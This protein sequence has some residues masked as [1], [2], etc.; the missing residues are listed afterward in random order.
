VICAEGS[1]FFPSHPEVPR[2]PAGQRAIATPAL[3]L[4]M[5]IPA[6]RRYVLWSTDGF[7]KIVNGR[8]SFDPTSFELLT[9]QMRNFPDRS[10]VARLRALGVHSVVL[11]QSLAPGTPWANTAQRPVTEPGVSKVR[12]G[13]LIVYEL[14]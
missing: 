9:A 6:N 2:P 4:P 7:P 12:R 11:H 3:Q 10:S 13:E 1:A 8:A 14:G 5:T